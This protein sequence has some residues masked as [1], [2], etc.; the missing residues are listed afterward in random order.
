MHCSLW[1]PNCRGNFFLVRSGGVNRA[2]RQA[3]G[4]YLRYLDSDDWLNPGSNERQFDIAERAQADVVVAGL[5]F[6]SGRC[7]CEN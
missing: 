1:L 5:D 3:R 6:L 7:T 4:T 2:L